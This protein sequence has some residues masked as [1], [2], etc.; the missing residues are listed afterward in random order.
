M[1]LVFGVFVFV[2][3]TYKLVSP[4]LTITATFSYGKR[5]RPTLPKLNKCLN[6]V[7]TRLS[8]NGFRLETLTHDVSIA[9][10]RPIHID[11][12][13]NYTSLLQLNSFGVG[14]L[15]LRKSS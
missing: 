15:T 9:T 13:E 14:K 1:N 3:Q 7:K 8:V 11:E 12:E 5:M 4:S 2:R 6:R 10:T